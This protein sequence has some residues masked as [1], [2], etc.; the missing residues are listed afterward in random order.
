[1]SGNGILLDSVI[2]IDHFNGVPMATEYLRSVG[3]EAHVSAITRAEVL[4]GLEGNVRQL[5][6]RFLDCFTFVPIDRE[7]ADLA[8]EL[9]PTHGWKLPD[10]LQAASAV[11]HG[12]MLATRNTRDFDPARHPFVVVPY[13]PVPGSGVSEGTLGQRP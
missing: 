9:R 4:T 5:G 12:L 11:H 8:A 7:I 13:T 6:A 10:A 2:L 1:M 3:G